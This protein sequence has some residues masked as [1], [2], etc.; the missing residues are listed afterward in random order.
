M[1]GSAVA[2]TDLVGTSTFASPL[3]VPKSGLWTGD[4]SSYGEVDYL[5]FNASPGKQQ[6]LT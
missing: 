4:L 3:P 5:S 1:Q 2:G 6:S